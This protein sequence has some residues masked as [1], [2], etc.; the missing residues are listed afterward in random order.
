MDRPAS[1]QAV[2]EDFCAEN[3]GHVDETQRIY[4]KMLNYG[5]ICQIKEESL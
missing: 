3:C 2:L 4:I 5:K 1:V